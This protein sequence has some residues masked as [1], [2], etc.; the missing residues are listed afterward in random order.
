MIDYV[1]RTSKAVRQKIL[2]KALTEVLEELRKKCFPW[3]RRNFL[4][5]DVEIM[6]RNFYKE[7]DPDV[8]GLY[9]WDEKQ[10]VHKIYIAKQ[11]I[12]CCHRFENSWVRKYHYRHLKQIIHHEVIHAFLQ[13]HWEHK[14]KKFITGKDRDSSPLFLSILYWTGGYSN[15]QCMEG[16]EHTEL[17]NKIFNFGTYEELEDYLNDM[18]LNYRE[19]I[20][21]IQ[22]IDNEEDFTKLKSNDYNSVTN[23]FE[24][25]PRINGMEKITEVNW[26]DIYKRGDKV[27]KY[28]YITRKW[29]VGCNVT[30][31]ML[32]A[33]YNRKQDSQAKYFDYKKQLIVIP[34]VTKEEF[35][36]LQVNDLK[37]ITIKEN[38][39]IS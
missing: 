22:K 4:F 19:V 24:F 38:K 3:K 30:P 12:W 9:E 11:Y 26:V 20:K 34:N 31:D 1:S 28:N 15:H 10:L 13:D 23:L 25:A 39:N 16:F 18:L 6:E 2:N 5:D 27:K 14:Y 7:E 33:L 8:L 17:Y 32:V 29:Q 21:P 37:S 35:K 36:T